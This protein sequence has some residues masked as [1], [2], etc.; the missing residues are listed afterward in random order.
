MKKLWYNRDTKRND[1]SEIE[2]LQ[3]NKLEILKRDKC[4]NSWIIFSLV[5]FK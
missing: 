1:I 3:F 4:H 2:Y 5:F